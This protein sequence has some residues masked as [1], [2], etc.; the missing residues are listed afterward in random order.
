PSCLPSDRLLEIEHRPFDADAAQLLATVDLEGAHADVTGAEPARHDLLHCDLARNAVLLG[1]PL[2]QLHQPIGAAGEESVGT[3]GRDQ[4]TTDSP[5]I[6]NIAGAVN[7]EHRNHGSALREQVVRHDEITVASRQNCGDA[8]AVTGGKLR[9]RCQGGEADAAAQ[10]HDVTPRWIEM[11][12]DAERANQVEHVAFFQGRQA[13]GATAD[14]LVE[15][16]DAVACAID[17]IDALRPP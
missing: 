12:S 3:T 16:L 13:P 8:D 1:E 15:K 4:L 6:L 10:H 11:E 2:H 17:A 7:I 9:D 14:A 5:D